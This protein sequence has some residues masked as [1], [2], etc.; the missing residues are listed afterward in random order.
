M[1]NEKLRK[2]IHDCEKGNLRFLIKNLDYEKV[3]LMIRFD[4]GGCGLVI[5]PSVRCGRVS[6]EP[7]SP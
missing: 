4:S 7:W 1:S 5:I 6:V 2:A 3:N